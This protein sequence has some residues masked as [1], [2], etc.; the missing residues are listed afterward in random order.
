M[1]RCIFC[2][3]HDETTETEIVKHQ[4]ICK[5]NPYREMR[6]CT[7]AE[8]EELQ[9]QVREIHAFIN[10]VAGALNNPMLKAMLPPQVRGMIGD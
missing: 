3:K 10:G 5:H 1:F 8:F 7:R 2:N 4:D 6:S 9:K